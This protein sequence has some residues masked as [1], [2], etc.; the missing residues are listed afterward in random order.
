MTDTIKALEAQLSALEADPQAEVRKEIDALND[1]AWALSDTD[2]QRAQSLSQKAHTLATSIDNGAEAYQLGSAYALRTLGYLNQRL[3][4]HSLGLSQLIEAQRIFESLNH[5]HGL[6]DVLDGMAGIYYQIGN[7]P[8]ALKYAYQQLDAAERLGDKRRIANANNNLA[9][10]YFDTGDH[11]RSIETLSKNLQIAA[12]TGFK[13]IEA[14]SHMN[15]AETYSAAEDYEKALEHG[16]SALR[17]NREAE[18]VLFEV[19]SLKIIGETYLKMGNSSQALHYLEETLALCRKQDAK[20]FEGP[21]LLSIGQTYR[22]MRQFDLALDQL[23]Q[24]LVVAQSINARGELFR[25]H[26]LM[27][28]IFEQQ[29]DFAQALYHFRQHHSVKESVFN[30]KADERLKVL[31]VVYDTE[32]ARSSQRFWQSVLDA[33]SA[34][35]AILDE[36]GTIVAVNAPWRRFAEDNHLG[37]ADYGIGRN[38]LAV[39]EAPSGDGAE[40]ALEAASGV[41]E[42]MAGVRDQFQMQYPCHSLTEERWFA[43]NVTRFQSGQGVQ[44]V[45]THEDITARVRTEAA[46][47][48]AEEALKKQFQY[49]KALAAC[50]RTL[51]RATDDQPLDQDN[52]NE[53]LGYLMEG[54]R[55][56]RAYIFRNFDDPEDGFCSGIVAESVRPGLPVNLY[57]PFSKKIPWSWAPEENRL[58]LEAGNPCGG[59]TRELFASAPLILENLQKQ[60]IWSV[61]FFPIHLGDTW[62]GYL[63]FD[64]CQ[65]D[66]EW[67]ESEIRLLRTASEIIGNVLQR[68][69]AEA[70][71]REAH[72]ELEKRVEQRTADLQQQVVQRELAEK[73]LRQ[74]LEVESELAAMSARFMQAPDFDQHVSDMLQD[75]GRLFGFTRTHLFRCL[76]G[77]TLITKTHEWCAPGVPSLIHDWQN[78]PAASF[79]WLAE[80]LQRDPIVLIQDV[81]ELPPEARAERE[82]LEQRQIESIMFLPLFVDAE[83]AGF[84]GCE[85][86]RKPGADLEEDLRAL[87][88]VVGLLAGALQREVVLNMLEERVSARTQELALFFDM[89]MLASQ[90]RDM[91]DILQPGLARILEIGRCR[92][93]CIHVLTEDQ[94]S[95]RLV[96]QQGVPDACLGQLET[97]QPQ[98]RLADWVA[99]PND[100]I[101]V[102]DLTADDRAPVEVYLAGFQAYLG[103]QLRVR[104]QPVGVL[105]C[106]W[107]SSKHFS[108][109][110]V[111][112][113]VA[114]AQQ[115]GVTVENNRLRQHIQDVAVVE[116]RQRLARDLH[117]AVTQSLYSMSLFARSGREALEDAD[118]PRLEDSLAQLEDNTLLALKEMRLLLY[119]LL[120]VALEDKGLA[121]A[122][123]LR[124]DSVERRLGIAVDYQVAGSLDLSQV[125]EMEVYRIAIEA[126]NNVLR[127]AGASAVRFHIRSDEDRLELEIS[128]NGQGFDLDQVSH[129]MGL[130]SMRERAEGLGGT[131][132][133]S[134]TPGQGTQ[135]L[136]VVPEIG[137]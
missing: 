55:A 4:D 46:R 29:G 69:A 40:Q 81:S 28:E 8:E 102:P 16:L 53:A 85:G 82:R 72:D 47:K 45:V 23:R 19:F 70:S 97:L 73:R 86:F 58:T 34:S 118:M 5:E 116:E 107:D 117:D 83:L 121:R 67:D 1:L 137:A 2:M 75:V 79:P 128:D 60:S 103:A 27:S 36:A 63:G 62:W 52:L 92:A 95:L 35:I 42:V 122:L 38:Y 111:S 33:L 68:W 50:S 87:K 96:A 20:P 78:V 77:G 129:G 136:L 65:T 88:V 99:G 126:L 57:N 59:P 112:L 30:E 124:F 3:G 17:A 21:I 48:S 32:T 90:L 24:G 104:G 84:L 100:P 98:E 119:Q 101:L 64:D 37:W 66:R 18:F 113:L 130:Q 89:T 71:L 74:R 39:A 127:H 123:D 94:A 54:A 25:I 61:Q 44:V 108:T 76:D 133:V 9:C 26:L 135:V 22:D 131:L 91:Q 109:D 134:S 80:R 56:D 43:M 51:H 12:E 120:P 11:K 31:Q 13:R 93:A 132:R 114:V 15:L 49:E 7:F 110:E 14:L 105:S 6:P 10:I 125:M 115:L 41:R 106:Y